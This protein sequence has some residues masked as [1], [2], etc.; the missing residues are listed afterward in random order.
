MQQRAHHPDYQLVLYV[1][2]LMLLGLVVMYA[3][4]PQRAQVLNASLGTEG[5]SDTFFVVRH[6]ISLVI[7]IGGFLVM[8]FLPLSLLRQHAG[9]LLLAG[10]GAGAVLFLFGNLL[11]VDQIAR[12]TNGA[13]RWI[14]LGPLG[15]FQPSELLKFGVLVFVARFLADKVKNR[16][17]NDW[18]ETLMPLIVLAGIVIFM[19]AVLQQDMGTALTLIAVIGCM[20]LAG[21]VNLRNGG[22]LA[23]G[24]AVLAIGLIASAPHRIER[25]ATFFADDETASLEAGDSGYHIRHAMIAIGSGGLTGVGIGNSVQATGYLPE[26]INDSVFAIMGETFGFVGLFVTILLFT[27]LLVRVLRVADRVRDPMH[28]L[29][30]VGVFGWLAS[31]I[32]LNIASMLGIFPLTG[33]TLPLLSLGGTSM[34]FIAAAL[35]TVFSISRLTSHQS[36]DMEVSHADTDRRRGLGRTRDASRRRTTRTA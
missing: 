14:E 19:V 9:K 25:V 35:G 5:Y 32:V 2:L 13:C 24:L 29:L 36:I 18:G 30:V 15:S 1:G 20:L 10:L 16:Q 31:H 12:C 26:A 34:L 21:G 4:G 3:I 27:A 28:R 8:A 23:A 22:I 7:A 6:V 11:G 33:I 17:V